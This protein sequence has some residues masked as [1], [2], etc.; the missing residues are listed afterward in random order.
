M[1][2]FRTWL[3]TTPT[4]WTSDLDLGEKSWIEATRRQQE[5]LPL[6]EDV[7]D[8]AAKFHD[9][10]QQEAKRQGDI[11]HKDAY[12][13]LSENIKEFDRVL[14]RYALMRE[15]QAVEKAEAVM[16]ERCAQEI[17]SDVIDTVAHR[18]AQRI[19]SLRSNPDW[20]K[21]H[22]AALV[23]VTVERCAKLGDDVMHRAISR[24]RFGPQ[25]WLQQY[26]LEIRALS[27][28]PTGSQNT[29][30]WWSWRRGWMRRSGGKI[31]MRRIWAVGRLRKTRDR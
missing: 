9:I 19:R 24:S 5:L 31:I 16:K 7:E 20:L 17:D 2:E 26:Q 21:K 12:A 6:S 27:Q 13:D 29:T 10:Y 25:A 22:D 23:A 1:S 30:K 14:V 18:D 11:R 15:K 8:L 28:T 3:N 4:S